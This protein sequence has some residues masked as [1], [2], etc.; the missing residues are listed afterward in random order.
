MIQIILE[1]LNKFCSIIDEGE[2]WEYDGD[3]HISK[4]TW[5]ASI[6]AAGACIDACKQ[7]MNKNAKNAFWWIRPPGHHA[8]VYGKVEIDKEEFQH[9]KHQNPSYW[10]TK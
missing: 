7:I 8:G 10:I 1:K 6:Y 3:T 2:L 9:I 4:L 5:E